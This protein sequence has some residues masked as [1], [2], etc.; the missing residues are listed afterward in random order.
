MPNRG[1]VV[2]LEFKWKFF[3]FT[4]GVPINQPLFN[5]DK[6][7]QVAHLFTL[8]RQAKLYLVEALITQM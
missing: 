8:I 4:Y 3:Y 6:I 5:W 7:M 1:G 2:Y